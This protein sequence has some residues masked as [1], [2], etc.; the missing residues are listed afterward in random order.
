M[1]C[2]TKIFAATFAL[3]LSFTLSFAAKA[4]EIVLKTPSGNTET[5]ESKELSAAEIRVNYELLG[6]PLKKRVK[7]RRGERKKRYCTIDRIVEY[8]LEFAIIIDTLNATKGTREL[9]SVQ[10]EIV[11]SA[12]LCRSLYK[13][14]KVIARLLDGYDLI[15]MKTAGR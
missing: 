9:S 15:R 5:I 12:P 4:E 8:N 10:K 14:F 3:V 7:R 11:H 2:L 1:K 13:G 6:M